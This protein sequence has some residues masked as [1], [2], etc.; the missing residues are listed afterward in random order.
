MGFWDRFERLA[1]GA[2]DVAFGLACLYG[3]SFLCFWAWVGFW[4]QLEEGNLWNP[5]G[6]VCA[7]IAI[8]KLKEMKFP[9]TP[10]AYGD[11]KER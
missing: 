8:G 3:A 4:G 11:P 7:V 10:S 9:H 1:K 5:L 6:V 2:R